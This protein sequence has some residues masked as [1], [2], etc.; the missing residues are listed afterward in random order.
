V[1]EIWGIP[2]CEQCAREQ[3]VYFAIGELTQE[4]AS[5]QKLAE[6]LDR[7]RR[8]FDEPKSNHFELL[9]AKSLQS[10]YGAHTADVGKEKGVAYGRRLSEHWGLLYATSLYIFACIFF[11]YFDPSRT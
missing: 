7:M 10:E 9:S 11:A 3:E 4:P 1:V 8:E 5:D 2:F 6:A